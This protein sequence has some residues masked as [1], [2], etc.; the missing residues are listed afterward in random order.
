MPGIN[1]NRGAECGR[2]NTWVNPT[3]SAKVRYWGGKADM[4][5]AAQMSACD[6]K[7]TGAHRGHCLQNDK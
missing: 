3:A 1:V 6:P 5:F 7:R 4:T 2:V